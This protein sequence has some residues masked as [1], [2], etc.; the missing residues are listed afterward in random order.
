MSWWKR[1]F[2]ALQSRK[3]RVALTTV[4]A[5]MLA[6]Y[7]IEVSDTIVYGILGVGTA[8]IL[9]IAHEDNGLKSSRTHLV[10]RVSVNGQA[11]GP[12]KA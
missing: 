10:Q 7:G 8:I 6:E 5:A 11:E 12:Q 9:G 1:P 3:V 2:R 4:V